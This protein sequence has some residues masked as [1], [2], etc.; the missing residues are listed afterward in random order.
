MI[1]RFNSDFKFAW[2]NLHGEILSEMPNTY[3][4]EHTHHSNIYFSFLIPPRARVP[5]LN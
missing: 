1:T 5:E 3:K 4:S 2:G